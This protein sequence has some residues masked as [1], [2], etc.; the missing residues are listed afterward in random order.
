MEQVNF[1]QRRQKQAASKM[2]MLLLVIFAFVL[3]SHAQVT[4]GSGVPPHKDALLE[5]KEDLEGGSTKGLLL[6]RVKLVSTLLPD[7]LSQHVAGMTVYNTALSPQGANVL[8]YVSPGFYYNTGEKWERLN[9]GSPNWFYMPSVVF[10]TS[11]A[12]TGVSSNL[13]QMYINQF[14]T[15]KIK[16]TGAPDSVPYLPTA[17]D[18]YYYITDYDT[19]VFEIVSLTDR[20]IL[21]YNVKRTS[22]DYSLINIVFVIK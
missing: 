22:S 7:P 6:P 18:L 9:P 2:M 17:T 4:I 11:A 20:G 19:D 8:E 21:T 13:Y 5:L 3:Q 10:D 12:A 16:S 14:T 15:P 1:K